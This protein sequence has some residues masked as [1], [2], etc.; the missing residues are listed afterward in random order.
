MSRIL[1]AGQSNWYDELRSVAYFSETEIER[2]I[3]Q[4]SQSLFPHHFVFPFKKDISSTTSA[5]KKRPDLA[6]IR[7]DFTSW[8]VVEVELKR[9]PLKHVLDQTLVFTKGN[10]NAPEIA[11]YARTQLQEFCGKSVSLKRLTQL[12]SNKVPSVL[13]IADEHADEWHEKLKAIGVSFCVFEI[14]K[15]VA[16]HFVFRTFGQYPNVPA[17]EVHCRAL[18]SM[19]NLIEV[20]GNF[21]FTK[22]GRQKLVDII[23]DEYLTHWS[24]LKEQGKQYLQ[25]IGTSNPLSPNTTYGLIRDK[26]HKY[27]FRRN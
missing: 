19:P 1:I 16:G 21:S 10:Y 22:I 8:A 14:Y 26:S 2:W 18:P 5:E 3:Q 6:L 24:L 25:F 15:N 20:I 27:Y 4:H 9:H 11:A 7:H 17:E 23:Y 13:V 12:I